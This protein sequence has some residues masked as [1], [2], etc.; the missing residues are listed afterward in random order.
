M[1]SCRSP[2]RCPQHSRSQSL[3]SRLPTSWCSSVDRRRR[4]GDHR[5]RLMA[6]HRSHNRRT[7]H[8]QACLH[9]RRRSGCLVGGGRPGGWCAGRPHAH[10]GAVGGRA[11]ACRLS[12]RAGLD[13][14]GVR[15]AGSRGR[16]PP[17]RR[18]ARRSLP[19]S[20][21]PPAAHALGGLVRDL[22][23][24]V[25]V[26][27]GTLRAGS[28]VWPVLAQA[29]A[30]VLVASPEVS[31]AVSAAEWVQAAGRVSPADPGL[32]EARARIL[33]VA[34]PGGL[35]FRGRRCR[36]SC[37]N[38]SP[39]GCRGRQRRSIWC[40]V[41]PRPATGGCVADALMAAVNQMVLNVTLDQGAPR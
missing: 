33:F 12:H 26:D 10:R 19:C 5:R 3:V 9:G 27:V 36:P 34:S 31:A 20:C 35:A 39:G 6:R 38:S 37:V 15:G 25:V 8:Q 1:A 17:R 22:P 13:P 18:H 4:A 30:V 28:P 2:S 16:Q 32:I 14:R 23:G 11:G 41:A 29:D 21:L 40:I 7:A 24:S